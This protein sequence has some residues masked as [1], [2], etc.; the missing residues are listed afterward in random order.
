MTKKSRYLLILVGF[1]FFLILAP[2]IVLYVRGISYDFASRDFIHT[3]ILAVRTEPKD[4]DIYLDGKLKRSGSGDISFLKKDQYQITLKSK[5]YQD[6]NK[7]LSI[8]AGQVTWANQQN[9][10]I[11]LFY[12]NPLVTPVGENILDFYGDPSKTLYLKTGLATLQTSGYLGQTKIFEV[13]KSLDKILSADSGNKNF[14]LGSASTTEILVVYLNTDSDKAIDLSNLFTTQPKILFLGE[15][16]FALSQNSLYQ[17]DPK[18]KTKKL[19][20]KSV[21]TFC[22]QGSSLYYIQENDGVYS[23]NLIQ[24]PFNQNQILLSNIA[25]FDQGDLYVSFNKQ[26]F[27]LTNNTLYQ[28]MGKMEKVADNVTA[29]N[30]DIQDSNFAIFHSG[31]FDYL[32]FFASGLNF[33]TRTSQALDQLQIKNNIDYAF[34]SVD[35]KIGAIELDSRD[36]QNQYNIYTGQSLK[37]FSLDSSGQNI[38]ILDGSDLKSIKIR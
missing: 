32:D 29:S 3:G 21:K 19:L 28:A 8:S 7:R 34:Y 16:I 2:L 18:T 10:Y 17:V 23:L 14:I 20:L 36:S 5:N 27:L 31:E 1:I 24:A 30:F 37:K 25:P 26:I 4:V 9:N 33:I 35:N 6:W 12:S 13:P 11:Y 38:L 15:D 22:P